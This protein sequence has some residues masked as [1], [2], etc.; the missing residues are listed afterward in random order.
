MM[1]REETHQQL[2]LVNAGRK[3]TS[4]SLH[5]IYYTVSVLDM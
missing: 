3:E 1:R 2:S 5:S 4:G